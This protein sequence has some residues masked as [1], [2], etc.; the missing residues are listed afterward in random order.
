MS[1]GNVRLEVVPLIAP[2]GTVRAGIGFLSSVSPLVSLQFVPRLKRLTADE[3]GVVAAAP[4]GGRGG[5][6][7]TTAT[8]RL[9]QLWADIAGVS[10]GFTTSNSG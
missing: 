10:F 1:A 4:R 9:N 8:P 3:T 2:M 7:A 5:S 6:G